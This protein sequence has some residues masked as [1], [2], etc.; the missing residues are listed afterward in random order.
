MEEENARAGPVD[1]AP[2]LEL[3]DVG[4]RFRGLLGL[5]PRDALA[6]VSLEVAAGASLGLIGPNGS[7][8]S[9]LLRLAAGVDRPSTGRVRVFGHD[10][11]AGR[12]REA[13]AR[14]AYLPDDS[15]FPGELSA[16]SALDLMGSLSG[17]ERRDRRARAERMLER[18]GLGSAAGRGLRT[19]SRGMLRRFG[20][21]Q[22]FLHDPD[23]VL[24]DEPTAGLDALG[25]EV[26]D[27]LTAEARERGAALV[28]ASHLLSDVHATCDGLAVL[29]DGRLVASGPPAEVFADGDGR[30]EPCVRGLDRAGREALEQWAREHGAH[31]GIADGGQLALGKLFQ[32]LAAEATR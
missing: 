30:A 2:A 25:F 20:L 3:T 26:L 7:G 17:L 9:T 5:A 23:L 12:P 13:R 19:Y 6:E 29:I 28:F 21:A 32:R 14:L 22:A 18:V 31:V 11:S 24:L 16:R 10:L 27:E 1:T 4:R 8:K 15:P